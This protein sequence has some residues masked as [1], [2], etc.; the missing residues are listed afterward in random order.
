MAKPWTKREDQVLIDGA[1]VF[2]IAWFERKLGR[3]RD[4]I[5]SRARKVC[6]PGGLCR[7]THSLRSMMRETGYTQSQVLRARTALDQK[8]KRLGPRGQYLITFE[9]QNEMV[10]WLRHDY[11]CPRLRLY[12]CVNCGGSQRP[13]KGMGLCLT[14]YWKVRNATSAAGRPQGLRSLRAMVESVEKGTVGMRILRDQVAKGRGPT[15]GQLG[16]LLAALS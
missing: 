7:G 3:S 8:W 12:S 14:C 2:A 5:E 4:A 6:G 9:Q 15:V 16:E 1:G 13:P 10:G 11:W